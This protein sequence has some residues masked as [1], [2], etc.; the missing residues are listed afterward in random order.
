MPTKRRTAWQA[1]F[2]I[3]IIQGLAATACSS[4]ATLTIVTA[5]HETS[6]NTCWLWQDSAQLRIYSAAGLLH[7]IAGD[8]PGRS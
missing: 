7:K 5:A 8:R 2:D 1:T 3:P 4:L 6:G